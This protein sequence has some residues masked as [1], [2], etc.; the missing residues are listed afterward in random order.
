MAPNTL[1][2]IFNV[3]GAVKHLHLCLKPGGVLLATVPGI[4]QI[5]R[6]DADR[7][8]DY[9]RFTTQSVQRVFSSFFD[10]KALSVTAFGNVRTATS[11]LEGYATEE[12]ERTLL[13]AHDPDYELIIAIRAE[14]R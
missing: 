7:W 4:S 8:G 12:L 10:Q 5:S 11:F 3:F 1:N 2:V 9:W 13:E 6:Y 14:K